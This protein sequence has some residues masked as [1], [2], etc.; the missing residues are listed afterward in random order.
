MDLIVVL[1]V[2]LIFIAAGVLVYTK[3]KDNFI[4][5]PDPT[6]GPPQF[7]IANYIPDEKWD[8]S[9]SR[10]D[11][12]SDYPLLTK[13]TDRE[14]D[15]MGMDGADYYLENDTLY[16]QGVIAKK[17]GI[18]QFEAIYGQ[19]GQRGNDF[20]YFQDEYSDLPIGLEQSDLPIGPS[21]GGSVGS[22][23]EYS[24]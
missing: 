24:Y 7:D 18:A 2:V 23:E 20:K 5:Y 22:A 17:H 21:S 10:M 1:L 13:Y 8:R 12:S 14:R 3:L 9:V 19:K 15:I 11:Y 16:K 4:V 6:Y